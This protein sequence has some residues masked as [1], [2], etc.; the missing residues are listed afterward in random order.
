M[1]DEL[2]LD[3]LSRRTGEP[4]ERLRQWRSLGLIGRECSDG[5]QPEDVERVRLVQLL[6]RRGIGLEAVNGLRAL[7]G[8][9][10]AEERGQR[11]GDGSEER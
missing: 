10:L 9:F 11:K 1:G 7:A 5:F 6:L 3:E 8:S 4:V 2:T